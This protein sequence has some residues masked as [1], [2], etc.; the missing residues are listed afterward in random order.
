MDVDL[1]TYF[2]N[3]LSLFC[4]SQR[5]ITLGG[6]VRQPVLYHQKQAG[7]IELDSLGLKPFGRTWG[8]LHVYTLHILSSPVR[9]TVAYY[10]L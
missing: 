9:L 2:D 10:V 4:P 3:H 1:D 5:Q 8:V 6:Y 7:K